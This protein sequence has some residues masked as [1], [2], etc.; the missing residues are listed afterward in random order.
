MIAYQMVGTNDL[1]RAKAFYDEIMAMLGVTE[2][3]PTPK[4]VMYPFAQGPGFA[5]TKTHNGE[6]ATFGNGAMTAFACGSPQQVAEVHA[7]VLALGAVDEG[8]PGD[9]GGFGC[10]AYFR[11]LDGNKLAL[12]CFNPGR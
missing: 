2:P 7:R 1:D 12:A 5:V 8:A 10:F 11:D 4:G 9:R 3:R 6:P